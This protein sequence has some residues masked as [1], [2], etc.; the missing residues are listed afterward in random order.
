LRMKRSLERRAKPVYRGSLSPPWPLHRAERAGA[1]KPDSSSSNCRR[2]SSASADF[3]T[4]VRTQIA[5]SMAFQT[6][7]AVHPADSRGDL[8]WY[9]KIRSGEILADRLRVR[10]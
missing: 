7:R 1:N 9:I 10:P 2:C 5:R 8:A 4:P 3:V 6:R